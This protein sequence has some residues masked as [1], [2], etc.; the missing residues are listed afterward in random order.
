MYSL[1]TLCSPGETWE[2]C[3]ESASTLPV[4]RSGWRCAACLLDKGLS[5]KPCFWPAVCER[6]RP[7]RM[8][9][10]RGYF[11]WVLSMSAHKTNQ[12]S[13]N[14]VIGLYS[15][16]KR[17]FASRCIL[18]LFLCPSTSGTGLVKEALTHW[19]W[20][21]SDTWGGVLDLDRIPEVF[22]NDVFAAGT[23]VTRPD[24]FPVLAFTS[25]PLAFL[26]LL[27]TDPDFS[28]IFLR[29]PEKDAAGV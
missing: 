19:D 3:R 12:Q 7:G 13:L 6:R 23:A 29:A 20:D 14:I 9:R 5:A 21:I 28:P 25:W 24:S 2:T 8:N 27:V 17:G 18:F 11:S 4:L 10:N 1:I 16:V 26:S 15:S 22:C